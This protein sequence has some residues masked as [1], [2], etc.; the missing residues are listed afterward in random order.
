M[1]DADLLSGLV[2]KTPKDWIHD[3][4]A[5]AALIALAGRAWHALRSGGGIFGIWRALLYGTNTPKSGSP[6]T[7]TKPSSPETKP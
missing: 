3:A 4:V 6:Q 1:N 5:I 2:G 7:E